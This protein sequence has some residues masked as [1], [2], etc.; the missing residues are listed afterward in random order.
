MI[1][2]VRVPRRSF[3]TWVVGIA[4]SAGGLAALSRLLADLPTTLPAS[5]L[6]VQHLHPTYPSHLA[7]ILRWHTGLSVE[8]AQNGV[9][10]RTGTVYL[11]PPGLHLLVGV[12]RRV[13]LSD[14]PPV[15]W[16][17]PS[18]DRLFASFGRSF[19][20]RAIAVILTGKGRDGAAGAQVVRRYGGTVIV[21]DDSAEYPGMPRAAT[22][23]GPVD[24]VLPLDAIAGTLGELLGAGGAQ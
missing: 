10:L 3:A 23:A 20:P 11:G 4:T 2:E 7:E 1:P 12:D 8:V 21:Q 22:Q 14:L 19:G 6:V 13:L 16:C 9:H 5:L 15:N 24:R 18:G 17:R